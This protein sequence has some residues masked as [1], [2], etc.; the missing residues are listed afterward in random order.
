[1]KK[2]L[3][4]SFF[5]LCASLAFAQA[6]PATVESAWI[7]ASVPVTLVF[8]NAKGVESRINLDVPVA[9]TAPSMD[10]KH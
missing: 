3:A 5:S 1:M 10:H 2:I 8:R 7:R 9:L 6:A 4:I